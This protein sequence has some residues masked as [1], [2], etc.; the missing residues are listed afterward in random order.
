MFYAVIMTNTEAWR[1]ADDK[2]PFREIV[3]RATLTPKQRQWIV[4]VYEKLSAFGNDIIGWRD[5]S[6]AGQRV[7]FAKCEEAVKLTQHADTAYD[8]VAQD[9]HRAD[10]YQECDGEPAAACFEAMRRL[11]VVAYIH[12]EGK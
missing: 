3:R 8:R 1:H 4:Q 12:V 10:S 11:R 6:D 9:E 7:Y 5:W 2:V